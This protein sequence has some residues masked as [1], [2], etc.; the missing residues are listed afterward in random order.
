MPLTQFTSEDDTIGPGRH[1]RLAEQKK[2]VPERVRFDDIHLVQ[3]ARRCHP[4]RW[5]A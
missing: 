1:I 3:N 5:I 4:K 2:V